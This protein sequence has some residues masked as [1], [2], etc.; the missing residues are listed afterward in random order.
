MLN[1]DENQETIKKNKE[2]VIEMILHN[3]NKE[4]RAKLQN[5]LVTMINNLGKGDKS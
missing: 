5:M 3:I 1:K 4:D 2:D